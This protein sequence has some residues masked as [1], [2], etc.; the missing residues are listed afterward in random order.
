MSDKKK[1]Y[2][3]PQTEAI[4]N[5]FEVSLT[6]EHQ[7]EIAEKLA[8]TKLFEEKTPRQIISKL[9]HLTS[10]QE[11]VKSNGEPLYI[12]KVYTPKDGVS[13]VLLKSTIVAQISIL[14]DTDEEII[15]SL[16]NANKATLLL[17]LAGLTPDVEEA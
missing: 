12:H 17:V 7:K 8:S 9:S 11:L 4:I 1:N 16:E 10:S 15:A 3:E 2:T 14:L 6:F 13:T 5:A